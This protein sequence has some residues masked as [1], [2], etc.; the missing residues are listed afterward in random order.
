MSLAVALVASAIGTAGAG[1]AKKKQEEIALTRAGEQLEARYAG[2]L[3][4]LKAGLTEVLPPVNQQKKSAF[5]R[6]R[7]DEDTAMAAIGVARAK[8]GEINSAKGLVGHAKGKWIGGADKGI[9]AAKA[10]LAKAKTAAEREAAEKDLAKWQQNRKEG[11][12]ALEERQAKLDQAEKERPKTE[13]AFKEAEAALAKSKATTLETLDELGLKSLLSSD[14]LDARLAKYVVLMEATPRGLAVFAQQGKEQEELIEKMLDADDLLVQMLVADGAKGGKYGEAM[15]I[16]S[17]IWKA[18]DKVAEGPL[19]KLALAISL[20]HA[21]PITQRNAVAKT[22]APATVDPVKRYLNYEN[23]LLAG[24]LDPAF[25][26]LSVWDYRMVVD[27]EEP[28]E[29][30]TWGREMLRNYRPDHIAT[31][32]YRWRYVAA[33]RSD[34]PYGSQ[35]NQYDKAELQFFQNILMNGGICG[36]R[37]FFGRFMLRSFGIPTTARPQRGHAALVHWTPDGW[38]PCLGAGWGSGWTKTIYDKDLDFLA[39][40]QARSAGESFMQVKRAQWIGDVKGEPRVFGLLS[41]T[42]PGF[43][44]GASLYLQ[45]GVIENAKAKT[46]AAVGEDIA[47]ANETKEKVEIVKVTM[48][49]KDRDVS[50]DGKGVITIPAAATSEPTK[51]SGKIIFMDSYLGGKQLHYSRTGGHQA[52]E[53]TIE[54]PTAGSYEL[55][56]RVSTPSWRQNLLVTVNGAKSPVVIDLPHTVGMWEETQPV[57]IELVKGRNLLRFTRVGEVKGISIKD[58][59]LTPG[60]DRVTRFPKSQ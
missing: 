34:I 36:R 32:D 60:S 43:W 48:T 42:T 27:G 23:A 14:K 9:A 7:E 26:D 6:A 1:A 52:F 13:K 51:S 2:E 31:S 15:Q 39:T 49:E 19:R 29:V 50:V 45:K 56:A 3:E 24:E 25:K 18:S 21:V 4:T 57:A 35:D 54:A 16:Y 55:T 12:E 44:Y 59:K 20:E 46:L 33:V 37:A 17:D 22:D 58:F 10:T 40:T 41:R 53:Y 30:L 8:M 28:D 5:L 38:V 11:E 47:E